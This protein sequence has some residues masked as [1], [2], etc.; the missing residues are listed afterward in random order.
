LAIG[1]SGTALPTTS[2]GTG[3][4]S[5]TANGVVYASSTSALTTGSALTF[6]GTTLNNSGAFGS[7]T[8]AFTLKNISASSISN[9][10]EQQFWAGNTFSGLVSIAAFGA[11]TSIG[12]GNQYGSFYWKIAYAGA[13]TEQMRLTNIGLGIGTSSPSTKLD[14]NGLGRFGGYTVATLPAGVVGAKAYV[15]NALTP[16]FGSTVVGGGSVTV[17]VFYNGSNWIVG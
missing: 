16:V 14:V 6:D 7:S 3:L 9:I 12:V 1:L 10:V 2:G 4:T 11:D 5:F 8:A 13:P 15:T 17:P